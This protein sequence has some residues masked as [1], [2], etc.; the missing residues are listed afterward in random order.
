MP[1]IQTKSTTIHFQLEG[2]RD[3]PTIVFSNSLGTDLTLWDGQMADLSK[4]FQILR[5]DTRGHGK[6]GVP[7]GFYTI[8]QCANDVLDLLNALNLGRVYFV[9][10][11]MGGMIGQYLALNAPE[12]LHKLVLSNTAAKIGTPAFWNPRIQFVLDKGIEPLA[13]AVMQRWLTP[14]FL[15]QQVEKVAHFKNILAKTSAIGYAGCCA[16]VRDFDA[17]EQLFNIETP[18]LVISGTEDIA[19]TVEDGMF[20]K[21]HIQNAQLLTV[22]TAHFG[23]IEAENVFNQAII[24]FFKNN[25]LTQSETHAQGMK[26]RRAVL[27]DAHVNRAN[28]KINAFNADFQHFITRY[29][30]GEIWTRTQ[31]PPHDRSLITLAMMIALNREDEFKMHV[32]AAINNGVTVDEIKEVIL[33]SGIYCGLPAANGAYHAAEAVLKELNLL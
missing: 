13:D 11:S 14:S 25:H 21:N 18:T 8:E 17:R 29:A 6:S 12:R 23:N 28:R 20:L 4:N 26:V 5:Y 7:E 10:L 27:G 22:Q 16:A 30:W 31:L 24:D 1:I 9:G 19:T 15:T 2:K 3:A 33:Q 32:K